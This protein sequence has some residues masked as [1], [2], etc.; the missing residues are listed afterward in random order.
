MAL[1]FSFSLVCIFAFALA[2]SAATRSTRKANGLPSGVSVTH[3][4]FHGWK[5]I[6]LRNRAAEAVIVPQIGRV[7]QFSLL[8]D[9]GKTAPGPLWNNPAIGLDLQADARGWTNFGGDK[10]WPAPQADWPK[11]TGKAWPPPK[12][13]DAVADTATVEGSHVELVSP[14]DANYGIR[15]RR[16]ISLDRQKPVMTI[17]TSYE[18]TQ[19]DSVRVGVWS[20]T[21]MQSPERAFILLPEHSVLP[22]GHIDLVQPAAKDLQVNGRLL[23]VTRDPQTRSMTGS[24]GEALLWVGDGPDLLIENLAAE[25]PAASAEWP[26][27]GSHSKIYTNAGEQMKYIELELLNRLYDLKPGK[28]AALRVGYT[29]IRRTETDPVA[30]AKKVF[31][32]KGQP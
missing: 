8:D 16:I 18:K 11:M 26:E 24:D 32:K 1:L 22:Q 23:S 3:T 6:V 5:A 14:V 4:D 17:E 27:Q 7:M 20:I 13:F 10:A 29:L 2:A 31:G 30:E 19:G 9:N 28:S 25:P 15:V 21:Q 12:T